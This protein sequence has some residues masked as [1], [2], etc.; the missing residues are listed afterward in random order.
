MIP[1]FLSFEMQVT[2]LKQTW[3]GAEDLVFYSSERQFSIITDLQTQRVPRGTRGILR[4]EMQV[5]LLTEASAKRGTA[6]F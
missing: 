5:Q 2:L 3:R 1:R 6:R 4:V